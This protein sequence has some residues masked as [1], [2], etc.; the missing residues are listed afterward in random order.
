MK[1]KEKQELHT[2]TVT[3]LKTLEKE[4]RREI[5]TL[6]LDKAQFKLKNTTYLDRTKDKLA[7]ILTVMRGKEKQNG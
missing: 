1:H 3:E 7:V 6:L 4:V 2:K 5:A